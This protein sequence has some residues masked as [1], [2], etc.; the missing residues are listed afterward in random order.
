[1]NRLAR[2]FLLVALRRRA[3]PLAPLLL[4]AP[5]SAFTEGLFTY[6][7]SNGQATITGI[8]SSYFGDL[9]IPATLGGYPVTAIGNTAFWRC[10]SL[11]SVK[12]P[13]GV[14]SIGAFAFSGCKA[15]TLVSIP[16]SVKEIGE[17]AFEEV[18]PTTLV[19]PFLPSGMPTAKL[20]KLALA[21]SATA[22]EARA[23]EGC[24]TLERVEIPAS[25]TE[26]G[27]GAFRGCAG[28]KEVVFAEGLKTV[29][30]EAFW[31][32]SAVEE[33]VLPASLTTL[34]K[35]VFTGCNRVLVAKGNRN[36]KSVDGVL[37]S[38][39]NE[40]LLHFPVYRGGEY[41]T[42]VNVHFIG[43][44]AFMGNTVLNSVYLADITTLEPRAFKDCSGLHAC[45]VTEGLLTI[46]AN[47][48]ENATSL[49]AF[50]VPATVSLLQ[51]GAFKNCTSLNLVAFRGMVPEL[52]DTVF[53]G[54]NQDQTRSTY[55]LEYAA[56]WVAALD[57]SLMWDGLKMVADNYYTGTDGNYRYRVYGGEATITG[58]TVPLTGE[59]R[60]PMTLDGHLVT[61]IAA[62]AFVTSTGLTAI[63]FP[64]SLLS[65]GDYAF[66]FCKKLQSVT[67]EGRP[68]A[69]GF[70]PTHPFPAKTTA[71]GNYPAAL[72]SAWIKVIQS[73]YYYGLRMGL[74]EVQIILDGEGEVRGAGTYHIDEAV[75]L[76]AIPAKGQRFVEWTLLDGT[77][78]SKNP[79]TFTA[80][81]ACYMMATFEAIA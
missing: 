21:T 27:E 74:V 41:A 44:E 49:R 40:W 16:A 50:T 70:T 73:G 58:T 71:V 38:A 53:S 6:K 13:E 76:E 75:A 33:M 17:G 63:T 42:P 15:L 47:A 26:I 34:G 77:T 62:R 72:E 55:P 11:T 23:F 3:L 19:A 78:N 67:F 8:A 57:G 22:I 37:F 81:E 46:Q 68:M 59:V 60:L 9:I 36:Y 29:G 79:I 1:M 35:R 7:V 64:K 69:K 12:I 54:M 31:G 2:L 30:D 48:F 10:D 32:C 52:T 4:T 61:G 51:D 80:T 43:E 45:F 18:L 14:T 56:I 66:A 65:I 39:N 28:L 25:V 5:L 24:S 20:R